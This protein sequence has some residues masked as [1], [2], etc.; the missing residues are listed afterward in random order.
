MI[1]L[2]LACLLSSLCFATS[3]V[4]AWQVATGLS[5]D[6]K[7]FAQ[8]VWQKGQR[9]YQID[10]RSDKEVRL[11]LI[12]V[13]RTENDL[14]TVG[15]D[16]ITWT[17]PAKTL[18]AFDANSFDGE[19]ACADPCYL[20][21]QIENG[22]R[23]GVVPF[24]PSPPQANAT[25][26][27]NGINGSGGQR[28]DEWLEFNQ[29]GVKA[30]STIEITLHLKSARGDFSLPLNQTL[31]TRQVR[32]FKLLSATSATLPIRKK[33]RN[34]VIDTSHPLAQRDVHEVTLRLKAPD[35]ERPELV[36]FEGWH[37]EI[38]SG[39]ECSTG[40]QLAR[41]LAVGLE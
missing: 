19:M 37:C 10:N 34:L 39:D 29:T 1:K 36:S 14:E 3:N 21:F 28:G 26:L 15:R 6:K 30:G 23:L 40:H 7:I 27:W 8:E 18:K 9:R 20:R 24:Q 22:A 13:H 4:H 31:R 41:G 5:W 32:S 38:Y 35:A 16:S 12:L 2:I 25:S 17:V 11:K 33:G